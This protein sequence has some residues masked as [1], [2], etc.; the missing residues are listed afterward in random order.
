MKSFEIAYWVWLVGGLL[1]VGL[2]IVVP[3]AFLMWI[4]SAAITTGVI[5]WLFPDMG[6]QE[7]TFAFGMLTIAAMFVARKF[8]GS[9]HISS[10]EPTLNQRADSLVGQITFLETAIE[11]GQ[12][13]R[14]KINDTSWVVIGDDMAAGT[15]VRIV[16]FDGMV[17]RAEKFYE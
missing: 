1:F 16:S 6:W 8:L 3:G 4:G 12:G 9:T 17:L 13:G 5:A 15:K 11:K 7:Q 10:D 2:E 14:A